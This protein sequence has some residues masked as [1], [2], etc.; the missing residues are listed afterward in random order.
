MRGACLVI[1][2]P[3][4]QENPMYLAKR[5]REKGG[6]GDGLGKGSKAIKKR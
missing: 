6:K 3:L 5:E 2:L 4:V 1:A